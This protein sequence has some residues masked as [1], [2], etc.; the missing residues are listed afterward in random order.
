M[1]RLFSILFSLFLYFPSMAQTDSNVQYI[2]LPP[3]FE[4]VSEKVM[5]KPSTT[6]WV[7]DGM[8]DCCI[9]PCPPDFR[10]WRIREVPPQ[11]KTITHQVLKQAAKKLI[12]H[13]PVFETVK[14][15]VMVKPAIKKFAKVV[16]T[17]CNTTPPYYG[18]DCKVWCLEEKPAEYK[19]IPH[20]VLK[21][22]A[23]F[24]DPSMANEEK[25]KVFE[26]S[27]I[28][29]QVSFKK[30]I[31]V[32]NAHT[33][34]RFYPNPASDLVNIEV[35]TPIEELFITNFAGKILLHFKQLNEK[36]SFSVS[37]FP[38]GIYFLRYPDGNIWR[39][40]RLMVR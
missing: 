5:M 34:L 36:I 29:E 20:Q 37:T 4:T 24:E 31:K 19:I 16:A 18:E 10:M 1:Q 30:S 11:Y 17:H 3:V 33:P 12:Y 13:P 21:S 7:K 15:S 22:P 35:Q 8:P 2:F 26:E 14:D 25:T 23:Y 38:S 40:E 28:A 9:S 32:Q 27:Q 39:S 6:K